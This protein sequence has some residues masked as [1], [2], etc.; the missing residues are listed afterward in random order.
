MHLFP[1]EEERLPLTLQEGFVEITDKIKAKINIRII[2][3]GNFVGYFYANCFNV[4][5]IVACFSETFSM[6]QTYFY[7]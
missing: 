2:F 6:I 1:K 7:V 5:V 4:P 3:A